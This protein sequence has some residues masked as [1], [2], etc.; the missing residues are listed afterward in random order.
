MPES[1]FS[2]RLI[3]IWFAYTFEALKAFHCGQIVSNTVFED[4]KRKLCPNVSTIESKKQYFFFFNC[5]LWRSRQPWILYKRHISKAT[6]T[7]KKTQRKRERAT[8]ESHYWWCKRLECPTEK[9]IEKEGDSVDRT[10]TSKSV[11]SN[12]VSCWME[13]PAFL[14]GS[15]HSCHPPTPLSLFLGS[16]DYDSST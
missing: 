3:L 16:M 2:Q 6:L 4:G 7:L 8:T 11:H 5:I 15:Q 9:K 1:P 14:C 13:T 12:S 10:Q